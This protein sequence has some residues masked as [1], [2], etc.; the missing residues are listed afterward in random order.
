M[1]ILCAPD[2]FKETISATDAAEAMAG[3]CRA[4]TTEARVATCP[5]ADGGEGTLDVLMATMEGRVETLAVRGPLGEPVGA[6]LG[7]V[8]P[9]GLAIV[10]LAE[11]SGLA[12]VPPA[13]RNPSRTSTF[14]TGQ[15]LRRAIERR[16]RRVV[17]AI[18]GSATVDGGVGLAQAVGVRFFD[19]DGRCLDAPLTGDD[20]LR[21]GRFERPAGLPLI[22]VACDVTNPLC[23]EQGAAV[24]YGPQKGASA[25]Q[26]ERLEMALAH[27]ATI[28]DADPEAPGAG[29]AG[30]VGFGLVA[31][32]GATLHRGAELV[33]DTV[34]FEG[35][36]RD[37][38]LVI[39]GEGRLD[40]QSLFGKAVM[41][42]AARAG[43]CD[44]PAVAI[45][46]SRG[47]GAAACLGR[48]RDGL[49]EEVVS[50]SERHG[51]DRALSQTARLLHREAH[52]LV[53]AR[54]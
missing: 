33:L 10:E 19:A 13:K 42:V 51:M 50:L 21:I 26:V 43:R 18:G 40:G 41:A 53:R 17:C 5:V 12:L 4:A 46:G 27:L 37:A 1:R 16:A 44:V 30:G 48:R 34:G 7:L 24:I 29:A 47:R 8:P 54:L 11:A 49:L 35:R 15:L 52:D 31:F 23:G 20:L 6:R 32:L 14:G 39:T 28:T 2:S 3:G 22:D 45:V 25:A 9:A 38:D 36:C